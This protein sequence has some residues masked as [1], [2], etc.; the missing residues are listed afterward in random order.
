M[1]LFW[2][3]AILFIDFYL[4][5]VFHLYIAE[6]MAKTEEMANSNRAV[7]ILNSQGD[8]EPRSRAPD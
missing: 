6:E 1:F 5:Y 2:N 8:L 7:V 4:I 3:Y